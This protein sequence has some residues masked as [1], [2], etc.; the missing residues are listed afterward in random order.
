MRRQGATG[1][2]EG[3]GALL[4]VEADGPAAA[5]EAALEDLA[6]A[7]SGEGLLELT[8][9]R[10]EAETRALWAT[11][12]ALSPALRHVA[13]LK[14]NEDV[15]VPVPRMGEL[16]AGLEALGARHR[17]A[18]VNFGHAGNGNI[19]VN[20]LLDPAE[21]GALERA[22]RCLEGVFDLVLELGGTLSGEHGVGLAKR[23]YVARELD[24]RALALMHAVKAAF[25]P[26]GILNPGKTLPPAG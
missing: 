18:I 26:R 25:D 13:P 11:R 17:I 1:I 16:V 7:A 15:V 21:P 12:K 5:L 6:A 23:P 10:D 14:I 20:L 3:A 4:L 24:P 9:A 8:L 2:P 22:E 19:H